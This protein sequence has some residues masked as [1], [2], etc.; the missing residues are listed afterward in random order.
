MLLDH[1]DDVCGCEAGE[2]GFCEVRIFG[3]KVFR[4]GVD[5]G[6]VAAAAS[7][8]EDLLADAFGMVEQDDA[9]AAA[10]CLDCAHHAG[11]ACAQNYDINLLH[12]PS[13]IFTLRS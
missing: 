10:A 6:E 5:V 12:S 13:L 2:G 7:G 1:G 11:R 3:E 4:A 9:A 8:D